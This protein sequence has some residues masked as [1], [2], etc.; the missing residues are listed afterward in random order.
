VVQPYYTDSLKKKRSYV[1]L[2]RKLNTYGTF[3]ANVA[4]A[5]NSDEVADIIDKTVL[6]TGSSYVKKHS[7][8]NICLNAY[9]GLYYGQQRQATDQKFV[10]VAG[11]YAP[12]GIAVSWGF[13]RLNRKPPWSL[14]IFASIIDVGSLVSYRFTHYNDTIANDVHVRLGQI[15]SPGGHLVIGLPKWPVSIGAGFN[16]APLITKVEKNEITIQPNNKTPLRW[17]IFAAVDIPLLNFYNKP[18]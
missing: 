6:P 18:R 16:W 15:V 12:L 14:S 11:V 2:I 1:K 10:S 9:T 13:A 4:K 3:I 7:V 17:E 5:D 8:F